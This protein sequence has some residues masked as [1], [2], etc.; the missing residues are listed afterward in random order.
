MMVSRIPSFGLSL[1]SVLTGAGF[2][3]VAAV[4]IYLNFFYT[5][6]QPI[7]GIPEI[8]G[9]SLLGGHLSLL[10][11]DHASTLQ[12]WARQFGWPIFQVRFGNRRV[13][14]LNGFD[15]AR[16]WLVT[17][18]AHT[19]DRPWFYTFHGVVSKTSAATIGTNPWDERTK[20]QRRVVG[21]LT[22]AP[23]IKRLSGL[24][25]LETADMVRCL[26]RDGKGGAVEITPHIYQ[27]RLALNI[28][29]MFCYGRRFDSVEDSML[30]Q[31]LSDANI[32]SR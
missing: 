15:V 23:A 19:V 2:C 8:P 14:V 7:K 28:V 1:P 29:L 22:T 21:S 18:Q 3:L 4:F 5:D 20:K 17:H 31:I 6:F 9:A 25:D 30:S 24:L 12:R 11:K 27:K 32:I 16:E 13:V 10:G 26:V